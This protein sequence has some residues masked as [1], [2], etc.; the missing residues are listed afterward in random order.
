MGQC[1]HVCARAC[2]NQA[3]FLTHQPTHP[4]TP[5]ARPCIRTHAC[6]HEQAGGAV[7]GYTDTYLH[8]D[9]VPV[10]PGSLRVHLHMMAEHMEHV[11]SK[12]SAHSQRV[13][14]TWSARGQHS[15]GGPHTTTGCTL[16]CVACV[17][18]RAG[19]WQPGRV[20][21]L[22]TTQFR[23]T[24][25]RPE[26]RLPHTFHTGIYRRLRLN[27]RAGLRFA[28]VP[29]Q[30]DY[31]AVEAHRIHAQLCLLVDEVALGRKRE[32]SKRSA[33]SLRQSAHNQRVAST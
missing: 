9:S 16:P 30:M 31:L 3:W 18:R 25:G 19:A 23:V 5:H 17:H 20:D 26:P 11:V 29:L 13:A 24:T 4:P 33:R 28:A 12:R 15:A 2:V 21:R 14:S 10:V 1:G 7:V 8:K 27:G 22:N 32:E 6:V